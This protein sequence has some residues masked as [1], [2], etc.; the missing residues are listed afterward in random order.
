MLLAFTVGV[1]LLACET[2]VMVSVSPSA[3]LSFASTAMLTGVF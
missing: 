3:S 1:P 2:L